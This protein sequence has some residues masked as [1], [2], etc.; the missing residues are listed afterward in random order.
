MLESELLLLL[1]QIE[2]KRLLILTQYAEKI[3]VLDLIRSYY[4]ALLFKT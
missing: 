2:C 4:I 1:L 3:R